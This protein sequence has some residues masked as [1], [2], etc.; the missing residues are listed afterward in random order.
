[1]ILNKDLTSQLKDYYISFEFKIPDGMYEKNDSGEN[2]TINVTFMEDVYFHI[3][4]ANM[5]ESMVCIKDKYNINSVAPQRIYNTNNFNINDKSLIKVEIDKTDN[6]VNIYVNNVLFAET[7]IL[8]NYSPFVEINNN[9]SIM[10]HRIIIDNKVS[11]NKRINIVDDDFKTNVSIIEKM[12]FYLGLY[13]FIQILIVIFIEY[14]AFITKDSYKLSLSVIKI[15][16]S[17]PYLLSAMLL[18]MRISAILTQMFHF[19]S[20]THVELNFKIFIYLFVTLDLIC[21]T[22][23][24]KKYKI[25]SDI[26]IKYCLPFLL[27]ILLMYV[28]T[29]DLSLLIIPM[30]V[31]L[32]FTVLFTFNKIFYNNI[33]SVVINYYYNVFIILVVLMPLYNKYILKIDRYFPFSMGLFVILLYLNILLII[34]RK[35]IGFS[36][37][38]IVVIFILSLTVFD[39]T[40][41]HV[42]FQSIYEMKIHGINNIPDEYVGWIRNNLLPVYTKHEDYMFYEGIKDIKKDS[43][44]IICFGGSSTE[45]GIQMLL[46][47]DRYDY[48][49]QMNKIL[50]K[51]YTVLNYGV[52]AWT[53]FQIKNY[54]KYYLKDIVKQVTPDIAILYI[55][56]ND[57]IQTYNDYS[58]KQNWERIRNESKVMKFIRHR[59]E[60]SRLFSI[61]KNHVRKKLMM[62]FSHDKNNVVEAVTV[63]DTFDNINEIIGILST[64][65]IKIIIVA[66]AVKNKHTEKLS[67]IYETMKL[68]SDGNNVYYFNANEYLNIISQKFIFFD[69]VHLT[70]EGDKELAH[71]LINK[72]NEFHLINADNSAGKK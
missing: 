54:C 63:K 50:G 5:K 43:K 32:I 47:K 34:Y 29:H 39:I 19:H 1:M 57:A 14:E 36:Q 69:D 2:K 17:I 9:N 23:L 58:F 56:Y 33:R 42:G 41:K 53:T 21:R 18:N 68:F 64:Y 12:L 66:E 40:L 65:K 35:Q 24:I 4:P 3:S 10:L 45:G 52:S 60:A 6:K 31:L 62:L 46:G 13:L 51:N 8:Q 55:G 48:P 16:Y 27:I 28:V 44:L 49:Y 37:I 22:Y 11:K 26:K 59:L 30:Y 72:L 70:E 20:T 25:N 38:R 61:G 15:L 71:Y 67:N 7:Y